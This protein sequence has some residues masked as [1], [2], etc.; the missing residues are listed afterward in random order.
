MQMTRPPGEESMDRLLENAAGAELLGADTRRA[1]KSDRPTVSD[2]VSSELVGVIL[3]AVPSA[4]FIVSAAGEVVRSNTA[5][6][7]ALRRQPRKTRERLEAALEGRT[8]GA[9]VSALAARRDDEHALVVFELDDLDDAP[10]RSTRDDRVE[11]VSNAWQLSQREREVL[12]QIVRGR[13][14]KA[15][16]ESLGCA[17]RTV[18]LHVTRLLEK[19]GSSSRLDLAARVLAR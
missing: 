17:V 4:A 7:S 5:G 14:N 10:P 3:E 9:R 2:L 12:T 13:T 15:I 18:E 6:A 1:R 16:S 11:S 8:E 19:S